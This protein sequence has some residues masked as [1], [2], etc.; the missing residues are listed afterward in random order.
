MVETRP[1]AT[2][3]PPRGP[4]VLCILDG[5]GEGRGEEDDAVA[6]ARTPTLDRLKATHPWRTLRAHG[7]AVGLPSDED[8][9]NSEVGHNAMGAGRVFD[10]GAKLVNNALRD[11]T[12]FEGPVWKALCAGR[13]LHL[14]GLCSDGNVHSHVDHVHILLDRA[15]RDGVQRVRLHLLT[16]GRDVDGRS[17][18]SWFEPLEARLATER[19]AGRDYR[20]ASGGG[21][22]HLTMDRYEADWAMVERGW[23]CHVEGEGRPFPT[24]SEAIR[25]LYAEDPEI[26]DQHLP[27]FVVTVE[28]APCGRIQDGDSVLFFNFRGDRALEISRAF[29]DDDFTVFDRHHRPNVTYAGMMQYDGDLQVPRHYLVAPPAIDRVVGEY[30]AA[31]GKRTFACSE[32]QKYG[33]VTYFFNGNRSGRLDATLEEYVEVPSDLQLPDTRPWMKAAEITDAV[34]EAIRSGRFDHVRLNLAN[35][36]MVGHTGDLEATRIAV[37]AVD[38]QVARIETAVRK[39]GGV[40]LVTA[41]HGNADEMWQRKGTK[42]SR[43]AEGEPLARPSHTLN[44]VPFIVVDPSGTLALAEVPDA[45]LASVGTTVL[46]LCGL[47]APDGYLPGLVR[48]R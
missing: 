10:Q 2:L 38:L 8:M 28:G 30:L 3:R 47:A 12:A 14:L 25:T 29:E 43:N 13:T 40:L 45:G 24:A 11:G 9:G 19:A 18:L 31:A 5:V 42:V 6:T 48:L 27:A 44:P 15:A 46:E 41:D 16:D 26:D 21:R 37:E 17:A 4:V 20:I 23:R 35:G 32:T 34:I 39:A 36:D 33:H 7:T 22:M 1:H